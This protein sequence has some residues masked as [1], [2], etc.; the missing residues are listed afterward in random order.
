MNRTRREQ[1]AEMLEP[2]HEAAVRYCLRLCTT[3]QDAQDLSHDAILA[4]WHGFPLLNDEHRF[5]PWF[6]RI[7][8]NMFRNQFRRRRITQWF[9]GDT[10]GIPDAVERHAHD[11]RRSLDA[12]RW[13]A[14]AM[15][16]LSAD[17]RALIVLFEMEDYTVAEIAVMWKKPE[18]TIKSRLAR[19]RAKMR[20]RISNTSSGH[21]ATLES[22]HE[23]RYAMPGT[24]TTSE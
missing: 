5:K 17:D 18:G 24:E 22:S 21:E 20:A 9:F 4:A 10:G 13:V 7:I 3:R 6:F 16:A 1:F 19:A 2:V 11:P 12:R 14:R 15:R 8:T 23:V